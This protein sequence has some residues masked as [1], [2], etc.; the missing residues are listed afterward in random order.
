MSRAGRT[1]SRIT[2]PIRSLVERFAF[3]TVIVLTVMFMPKGIGGL[4]DRFIVTRRFIALRA[5]E[6]AERP[7]R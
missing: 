1:L 6:S 2:V 4:I 3:G 5:G 7:E